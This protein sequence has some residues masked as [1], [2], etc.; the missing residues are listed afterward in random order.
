MKTHLLQ[1]PSKKTAEINWVKPLNQYLLSIYGST[2]D[3]QQDLDGLNKLR[4]D[5]TGVHADPTGIR[6]Y[7]KYYSQLELLDLR[8]NFAT[9]NK[10]KK[11][12]FTWYDAFSTSVVHKQHALPFEKACV[13]FNLGAIISKFAIKKYEDS[14]TGNDGAFK[15]AI[16]LFLQAAGVYQFLKENFLHAP[17]YD[18][19]QATVQFLANL[20]LSQSQELFTLK[21]IDGDLEQRKNAIIAKL[22]QATATRYEDLHA[23]VSHLPNEESLPSS[24]YSVVESEEDIEPSEYD[25]EVNAVA[26]DKVPARVDELWLA[27]I[28]FKATYYRALA[29]YFQGLGLE[30]SKKYGDAIAYLSKSQDVLGEI[31]S[32]LLK[33]ISKVGDTYDLLDN[34]KYHKDAVGIKLAD[35]NKDNDLIYHDVIPSLVTL[36]SI[37]P[38]DSAKSVA[39]HQIPSFAEANDSNYKNFLSNVVPINIHELTSFY[40]EEKS[41]LLRNEIDEVDVS[42]EELQSVLEYLKLPKALVNVK[43]ILTDSTL[44][45]TGPSR[46]SSDVY[47]KIDEIADGYPSDV[48]NKEAITRLRKQIQSVIVQADS[49]LAGRYDVTTAKDELIRLK[50]SLYDASG[51]DSRIFS[52]ISNHAYLYQLAAKGSRASEVQQLFQPNAK[53]APEV[54]LLDIDDFAETSSNESLH[55]QIRV[56]EDILN[57]LNVI[58]TNKTRVI[59]G[60]KQDIHK[61]DISDILILNSRIK[62]TNEI[63][64]VIFPEELKKFSSYSTKLDELIERQKMLI[65]D[66]QT[67]WGKLDAN[68]KI[69]EI[70]SSKQF[71]VDLV[72]DQTERINSLYSAWRGYSEGLAKGVSIYTQLLDYANNVKRNIDEG[73]LEAQL[74]GVLLGTRTSSYGGLNLGPLKSQDYERPQATPYGRTSVSSFDQ[75]HYGHPTQYSRAQAPGPGQ[76]QQS[77]QQQHP[78]QYQQNVSHSNYDHSRPPLPPKQPSSSGSSQQVPPSF[79]N[80]LAQQKPNSSLIYDQPSTYQPNMYNFFSQGQ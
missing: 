26:D 8:I 52:L 6:L 80:P 17:S 5:I 68:P 4:Q 62:S 32:A 73:G 63:K 9:A 75:S 3:Y 40:S 45:T 44:D 66:L 11:I 79:T 78:S 37:K 43:S 53:A 12:N 77:S 76:Y 24:T 19:H 10:H 36:P 60:L 47:A 61:D 48:S 7:F 25:P 57:E 56:V 51:A 65:G 41:Q 38:M 23:T 2:S 28:L 50:K 35:L 34:Y 15:E 13:L 20:N 69:K 67:E 22:C 64:S 54:S 27:I 70:Q 58:R 46:P 29:L 42:N 30:A 16:T 14:L 59:D 1:I 31:H 71:Q 55:K 21:V 33:I 49:A 74:S 39:I 72:Q 18:L